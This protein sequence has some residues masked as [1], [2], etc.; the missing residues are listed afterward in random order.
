MILI[1]TETQP[2]WR[3]YAAVI[4]KKEHAFFSAGVAV[5]CSM[6]LL[7]KYTFDVNVLYF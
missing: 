4:H 3:K 5:S 1:R 2:D 7:E 6:R